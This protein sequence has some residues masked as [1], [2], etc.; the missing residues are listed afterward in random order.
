MKIHAHSSLSNH[1]PN[2]T[3]ITLCGR[4][5]HIKHSRKRKWRTTVEQEVTCCQCLKS[6]HGAKQARGSRR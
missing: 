1:D 3:V 6:L 5:V 2:G 4:V